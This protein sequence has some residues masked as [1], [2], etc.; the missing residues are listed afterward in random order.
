[1]EPNIVWWTYYFYLMPIR[2]ELAFFQSLFIIH[3]LG[4]PFKQR[5]DPIS[6]Y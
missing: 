3:V 4:I 6:L 2:M 1:M 5:P